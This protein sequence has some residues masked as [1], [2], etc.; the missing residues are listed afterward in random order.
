MKYVHD[1]HKLIIELDALKRDK[2]N[3]LWAERG[4]KTDYNDCN[5]KVILASMLSF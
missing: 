1:Y 3:W 2:F 5:C 4:I